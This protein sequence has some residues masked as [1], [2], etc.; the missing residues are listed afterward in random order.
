MKRIALRD[1]LTQA[2]TPALLETLAQQLEAPATELDLSEVTDIDSSAVSLLLACQRRAQD[3]GIELHCTNLPAG[4][5]SLMQLYS[6]AAL[7]PGGDTN[8]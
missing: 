7:I 8:H 6:V 1:E 3:K 4:L 5:R 2:R